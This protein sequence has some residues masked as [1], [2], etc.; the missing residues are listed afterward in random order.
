MLRS[1]G[2]LGGVVGVMA[3]ATIAVTCPGR[4]H[5]RFWIDAER[6][7]QVVLRKPRIVRVHPPEVPELAAD[8]GETV[9]GVP[10]K[11]DLQRRLSRQ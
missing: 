11:I 9:G 4:G 1:D 6:R 2:V 10:L 7:S 8:F 5:G 3:L